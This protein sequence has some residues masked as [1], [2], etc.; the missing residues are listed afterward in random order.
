MMV[1]RLEYVWIDNNYNLRSKVKV[2]YNECIDSINNIPE[3]NYD[4]SSTNQS[5]GE[6]SEVIIKPQRMFSSTKDPVEPCL[7][8]LSWYRQFLGI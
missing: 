2:M 5:S 4:G 8:F 7:L 1:T 6:D 3:W